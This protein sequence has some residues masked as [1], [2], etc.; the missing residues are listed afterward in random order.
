MAEYNP[1]AVSARLFGQARIDASNQVYQ[2]GVADCL[3]LDNV[4]A[5][6]N[7]ATEAVQEYGRPTLVEEGRSY[8]ENKRF[9]RVSTGLLELSGMTDLSDIVPNDVVPAIRITAPYG[10]PTSVSGVEEFS[11]KVRQGMHVEAFM[12]RPQRVGDETAFKIRETQ[13]SRA[14][15]FMPQETMSSILYLRNEGKLLAAAEALPHPTTHKPL[16]V[17][18]G[19]PYGGSILERYYE[20][21]DEQ[22]ERDL[23]FIRTQ[24][25]GGAI[26]LYPLLGA[27]SGPLRNRSDFVPAKL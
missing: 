17:S 20:R 21:T 5:A 11:K 23:N 10:Q 14:A 2:D 16:S 18:L 9:H 22:M 24:T 25:Y 27:I 6:W 3:I 1:Q 19:R 8:Y 13:T 26:M 12:V 15:R 7:L 4:C